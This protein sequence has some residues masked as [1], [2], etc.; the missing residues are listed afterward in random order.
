MEVCHTL[1][2]D[3]HQQTTIKS[4]ILKWVGIAHPTLL[5]FSLYLSRLL[6][7]PVNRIF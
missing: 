2:V 3:Q 7:I 5:I 1:I 6:A 4:L